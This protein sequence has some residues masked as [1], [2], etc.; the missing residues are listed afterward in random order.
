MTVYSTLFILFSSFF[1]FLLFPFFFCLLLFFP[2]QL[3]ELAVLNLVNRSCIPSFFFLFFVESHQQAL[4]Y[5]NHWDWRVRTEDKTV[6]FCALFSTF[7]LL[8]TLICIIYR[9]L[10]DRWALL[11]MVLRIFVKTHKQTGAHSNTR[12]KKKNND[13]T[14]NFRL[15]QLRLY[16][17][18]TC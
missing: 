1:F 9:V 5:V 18:Q 12:K 15:S 6:F 17:V 16:T 8:L 4:M 3:L 11:L 7:F 10:T 13:S 2:M 14:E